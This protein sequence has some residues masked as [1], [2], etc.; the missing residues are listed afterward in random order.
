[1]KTVEIVGKS[2]YGTLLTQSTD[3]RGCR[4]CWAHYVGDDQKIRCRDDGQL[5]L[6]AKNAPTLCDKFEEPPCTENLQTL[7]STLVQLSLF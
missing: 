5:A 3:K 2:I 4:D 6:F 1:M 7:P